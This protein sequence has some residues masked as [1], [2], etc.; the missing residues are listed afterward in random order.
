[1]P[2]PTTKPPCFFV[3]AG[4]LIS[5]QENRDHGGK[6]VQCFNAALYAATA[7]V[8][9]IAAL[10]F[11]GRR[12]LH[13]LAGRFFMLR[14]TVP[15]LAASSRCRAVTRPRVLAPS[16]GSALLSLPSMTYHDPLWGLL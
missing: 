13:L 11:P 6:H 8:L 4:W 10:I 1:M 12:A 7:L 5:Q 16:Q 14:P 9:L 15:K 2:R 3:V